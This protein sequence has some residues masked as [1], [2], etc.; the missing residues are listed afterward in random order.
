MSCAVDVYMFSFPLGFMGSCVIASCYEF[1]FY[2]NT[3]LCIDLMIT[4][5][6]NCHNHHNFKDPCD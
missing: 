2:I 3:W 1:M 5:E 4:K 6:T